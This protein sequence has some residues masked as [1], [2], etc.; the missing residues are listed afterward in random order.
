VSDLA[1]QMFYANINAYLTKKISG[2]SHGKAGS[3]KD[4]PVLNCKS[5]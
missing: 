5:I 3:P 1:E 2:H 4:A